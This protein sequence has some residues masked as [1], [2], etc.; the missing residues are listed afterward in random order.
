MELQRLTDIH[1]H[2]HLDFEMGSNGN[3]VYI[4]VFS[5]IA[6][7]VLVIAMINYVNLTTARA[8][9]RIKEIGIRKVIGS[10]K[11]QLMTLF[12]SESLLLASLATIAGLL[13]V[14]ILLPYFNNLSGK[15]LSVW[16]FGTSVSLL[17]FTAF[18]VITGL[19]SGIYPVSYTHLDV[20]KR[21]PWSR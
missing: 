5:I 14:R 17:V 20:Y 3:I 18:A 4:Y 15:T 11:K 6:L 10:D 16:Q 1:L 7:L 2:S 13:L 9:V 19:L 8:S 12:F 21:Q